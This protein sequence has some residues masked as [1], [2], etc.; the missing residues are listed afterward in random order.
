MKPISTPLSVNR[1]LAILL[2]GMLAAHA[3][4]ALGTLSGGWRI[5]HTMGSRITRLSPMQGFCAET[6]GSITLFAA[7]WLGIPVSTTHTITGAIIGVGAAKKARA[8]RWVVAREIVT[9]WI[10]TIPA[11]GA[12][13]A[14]GELREAV[15]QLRAVEQD[16]TG[17]YWPWFASFAPAKS[18]E[19]AM[20]VL[21]EHGGHGASAAAPVVKAVIVNP[22]LFHRAEDPFF[23]NTHARI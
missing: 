15:L 21:V 1:L 8:V 2:L 5:V 17:Y 12:L 23:F 13:A 4:I 18:P 6:G 22:A 11:A 20:A 9:A 14:Q 16:T 3:A 10:L 7:T 19:I